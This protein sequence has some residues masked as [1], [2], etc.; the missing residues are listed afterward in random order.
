[1]PEEELKQSNNAGRYAWISVLVLFMLG[2][3]VFTVKTFIDDH[4]RNSNMAQTASREQIAEQFAPQNNNSPEGSNEST[5]QPMTDIRGPE[6]S[7]E[8]QP[9]VLGSS[10]N[11]SGPSREPTF[12]SYRNVA[13]GFSATIPADAQI[14]IAD[15]KIT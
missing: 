1:M 5:A 13:F 3:T 12:K 15:N 10:L 6:N 8:T 7:P 2:F 11:V 9:Q 4:N 14:A